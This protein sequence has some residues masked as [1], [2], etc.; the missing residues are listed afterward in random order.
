ML[1]LEDEWV[2]ITL[3]PFPLH[4]SE[5]AHPYSEFEESMLFY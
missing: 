5:V 4:L 1:A 2:D 3:F